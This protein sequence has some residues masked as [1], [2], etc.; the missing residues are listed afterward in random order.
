MTLLTA[1]KIL[2][3][4]AIALFVLYAGYEARRY[5]GGDAA[6]GLRALASAAGAAGFAVYLRSVFRS[7]R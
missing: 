7:A 5:L 3:G 4:S 6:A 2:I 1:H